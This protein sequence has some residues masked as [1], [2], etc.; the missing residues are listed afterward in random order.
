LITVTLPLA[1]V[2]D[3]VRAILAQILATSSGP[4]RVAPLASSGRA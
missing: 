1:A 4:T 3:S 2:F